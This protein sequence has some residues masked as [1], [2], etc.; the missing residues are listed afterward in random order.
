M[1]VMS[2]YIASTSK[3]PPRKYSDLAAIDRQSRRGRRTAQIQLVEFVTSISFSYGVDVELIPT[4]GC[5]E[6]WK[7]RVE[8][9]G[10]R[11]HVVGPDQLDRVP[12]L[13]GSPVVSFCNSQFISHAEQFRDLGCPLIWA[14]CMTFMFDHEREC[15]AKIGPADGV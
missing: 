6:A 13:P 3:A 5:D 14:N 7:A 8:A 10:C 11:T 15:F 12:N 2:P 9:L 4:W 1:Y